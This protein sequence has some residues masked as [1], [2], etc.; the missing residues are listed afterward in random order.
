MKLYAT[1]LIIAGIAVLLVTSGNFLTHVHINI[2]PDDFINRIGRYQIFVLLVGLLVVA[3]TLVINHNSRQY[4]RP[5]NLT[6]RATREKW[7]GIN[8][9]TSWL[10]IGF[11]LLLFISLATAIFMFLGVYYTGNINN[12][13]WSFMGWVIL[14]SLT[15]SLSE[16]LIFR[17]GVIGNLADQ[18]SKM[19]I[20]LVSAL[21]FGLPHYFG[22]PGG[23]VGVI[24]SGILGY[25]LCK[26]T[27]ETRGLSVAWSI[28][29]VQDVIIYLAI[30]MMN[31]KNV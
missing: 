30:F 22:N 6:N 2:H 14:F 23:A 13:Q 10:T 9:Q 1:I 31:V 28:H 25:I 7:L 16:E 17:F 27:L 20:L 26:A 11:Q 4:L 12:F 19:T 24:M 5:G 3:I 29:F 15:N 8:G 21:L 18:Y